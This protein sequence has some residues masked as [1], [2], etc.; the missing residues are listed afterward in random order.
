MLGGARLA[1]ILSKAAMSDGASPLLL[2]WNKLSGEAYGLRSTA[3][4]NDLK[5]AIG[6]FELPGTG[7][8]VP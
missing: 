5:P 7:D 2:W 4:R 8:R 1:A 6:N 3:Y